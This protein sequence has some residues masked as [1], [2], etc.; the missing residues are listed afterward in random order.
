MLQIMEQPNQVIPHQPPCIFLKESE[1]T[2]MYTCPY[3]QPRPIHSND[4]STI[5]RVES[6]LER[7]YNF[8]GAIL[9]SMDPVLY[10]P[11]RRTTP[12]PDFLP[13]MDPVISMPC[14]RMTPVPDFLPSMDPVLSIPCR[15]MTP[16]PDL[17]IWCVF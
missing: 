15:R 14:R 11:C 8:Y 3:L 4:L 5:S 1:K 6:Y 9:P 13:S 2:I 16:V 7:N 12:V 17:L 10:I